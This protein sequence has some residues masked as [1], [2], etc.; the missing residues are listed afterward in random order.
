MYI[1]GELMKG[2]DFNLWPDASNPR[3]CTGVNYRG[4]D[5]DVENI[6]AFGFVK[7]ADSPMWADTPWGDYYKPTS[8]HFKGDLDDVRVFNAPFSADDAKNLYN[9]EK[10]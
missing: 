1:N 6:L 9:A 10:P 4:V 8:N 7:S 5:T 3:T 2:Q